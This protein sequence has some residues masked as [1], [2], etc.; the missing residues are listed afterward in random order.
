MT[1]CSFC[2]SPEWAKLHLDVKKKTMERRLKHFCSPL[3]HITIPTNC[4]LHVLLISCVTTLYQEL[5]TN[6]YLKIET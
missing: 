5:K 2:L 6:F 4:T 3:T 1:N